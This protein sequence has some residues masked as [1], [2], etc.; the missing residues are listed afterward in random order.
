[1][2]ILSFILEDNKYTPGS[3]AEFE[4]Q[5]FFEGDG[6]QRYLLRFAILFLSTV[7]ATSTLDSV[8]LI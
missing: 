7:F 3:T 4:R 6:A 2:V 5:L 1:M 8:F